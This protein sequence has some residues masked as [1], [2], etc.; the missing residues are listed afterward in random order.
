MSW[1]NQLNEILPKLGHRNWILVVDKAY[2]LQSAPGI[3]TIY[4][5]DYF[6]YVLKYLLKRIKSEKHVRPVAYTDKELL[7][8]RDD[9]SKGVDSFKNE[10]N[11]ILAKTEQKNIPHE[12]VFAKLEEASRMFTVLVL[13]TDCK[14]P[15]TS[16]FL[17]LDCGYW[18]EEKENTLRGRLS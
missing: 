16:V 1:K 9:L 4:T 3:T 7:F 10:L 14:I 18:S 13:K 11:Q 6:P 2:P 8:M 12:E 5:D 15:Y 17:E